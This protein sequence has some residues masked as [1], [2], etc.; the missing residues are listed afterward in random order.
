[1]ET[2]RAQCKAGSPAF[3]AEVEFPGTEQDDCAVEEQRAK[4]RGMASR[5]GKLEHSAKGEAGQRNASD[6]GAKR[7]V[8][9]SG[10]VGASG[11]AG[12]QAGLAAFHLAQCAVLGLVW[13]IVGMAWYYHYLL[14]GTESP[15][16]RVCRCF[17]LFRCGS[18]CFLWICQALRACCVSCG[19]RVP[20]A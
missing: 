16:V 9:V 17:Y 12:E 8:R 5:R 13:G 3:R 10:D 15:M 20:C 18:L 6:W 4:N 11:R 19:R 1:M 7:G 2:R 14:F